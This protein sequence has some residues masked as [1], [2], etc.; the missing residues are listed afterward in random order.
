MGIKFTKEICRC[1]FFIIKCIPTSKKLFFFFLM[2]IKNT[3]FFYQLFKL[4]ILIKSF[5]LSFIISK[6]QCIIYPF[7]INYNL[8]PIYIYI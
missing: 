8:I 2:F 4:K 1:N 6:Q 5:Y 3:I 7:Y